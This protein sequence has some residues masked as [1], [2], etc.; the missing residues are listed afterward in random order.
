[1]IHRLWIAAA[2]LAA[3]A[4][5]GKTR[6]GSYDAATVAQDAH[7]TG[8]S[9]S[10][11]GDLGLAAADA[12]VAPDLE[13]AP[14]QGDPC[15]GVGC[16]G[17][18][19][20]TVDPVTGQPVCACELYY[21]AVGL[22]CVPACSGVSCPPGQ[23]CIPGHH[24][25]TDP[26]CVDTCDCSNCGNCAMSDFQSYGVNYCGSPSGAPA[27]VVCNNPCPAGEGC[28]PYATPICWP[29]QGCISK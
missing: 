22:A 19:S 3:M 21:K 14:N 29:G 28:I 18:G 5:V 25:T 7:P 26:M 16:S 11:T 20:C 17:H 8:L 23:I 9:D 10:T 15:A 1:M 4:C 24:K 12:G 13:L 27:T 2:A 6:G